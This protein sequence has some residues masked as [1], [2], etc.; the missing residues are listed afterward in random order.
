MEIRILKTDDG[1][2]HGYFCY[3][4]DEDNQVKNRFADETEYSVDQITVTGQTI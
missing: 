1:K 2:T 4:F 3:Q